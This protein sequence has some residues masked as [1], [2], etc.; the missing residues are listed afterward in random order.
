MGWFT[1]DRNI[2][3]YEHQKFTKPDSQL[4]IDPDPRASRHGLHWGFK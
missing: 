2:V 3:L 4:P 1:P